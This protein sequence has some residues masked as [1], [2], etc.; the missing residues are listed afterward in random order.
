MFSLGCPGLQHGYPICL[1]LFVN[2]KLCH[3]HLCLCVK[4]EIM[5]WTCSSSSQA[6]LLSTLACIS[7]PGVFLP[8]WASTT[9]ALFNSHKRAAPAVCAC[10]Y[11]SPHSWGAIQ[12]FIQI[13]HN[14]FWIVL[15]CVLAIVPIK[16]HAKYMREFHG[17]SRPWC[18]EGGAG[19]DCR[20]LKH[21]LHI[22]I[23]D[24][25]QCLH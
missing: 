24:F 4:I 14:M 22:T 15:K 2:Q 23:T 7:N 6:N 17:W 9:S 8:V 10:L 11:A 1:P 20:G 5:L 18:W 3:F 21:L 25:D 12:E 16:A 19:A 13:A